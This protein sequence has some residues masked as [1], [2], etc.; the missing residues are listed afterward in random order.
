MEDILNELYILGKILISVVLGG[1]IGIER[2]VADKP[3]GFRT[4]MFIAGSA[5]IIVSL[6]GIITTHYAALPNGEL[7]RTDPIRLF[8]AIVVGISFLGAGMIY[9]RKDH[10][11]KVYNLTTAA[12]VLFTAAVGICV[13]LEEYVLAVGLTAMSVGINF[14]LKFV[15]R[16]LERQQIIE[17]GS[18]Y[19]KVEDRRPEAGRT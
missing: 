16:W 13:A 5:T 10:D 4:N 14:G 18:T 19:E 11:G 9:S 7:M 12:S 15:D 17:P 6:G 2:K 3:A 8:E 1:I